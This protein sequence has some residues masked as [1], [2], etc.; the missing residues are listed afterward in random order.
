MPVFL[1]PFVLIIVR[2]CR[3]A[4]FLETKNRM[5]HIRR[6][7]G[8]YTR[9]TISVYTQSFKRKKRSQALLFTLY[10]RYHMPVILSK[11]D[12]MQCHNSGMFSSYDYCTQSAYIHSL[13]VPAS[14]TFSAM[15]SWSFS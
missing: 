8:I 7:K 3:P 10:G 2:T 15:L 1:L 9:F 6:F 5:H 11:N 13:I 12:R 4:V 14:G